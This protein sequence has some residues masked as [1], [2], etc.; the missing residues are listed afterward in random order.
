MDLN[1][2]TGYPTW[3]ILICILAGILGSMVL[4]FRE[5]KNEFPSWLKRLLG[6]IRF[7]II[8]LLSFL[9]LSP[10]LKLSSRATERP[11][12]IFAQDNSLSMVL[13]KDSVYYRNNYIPELNEM[14]KQLLAGF[15]VQLFT[16]GEDVKM[17]DGATFDSL[18]FKEKESD[19]SA[20][21]DMMD[22]SFVNR[23]IGAV[24]IAGDGIYNK[25]FNPVYRAGG[26]D[27]PVY[28]IGLGDTAV[29][30][31]AFFKRVLHNSIAFE[32]NDHPV[33]VIVN[34][35]QMDGTVL[36][37]TISEKA[38]V[39]K[40]FQQP[41][42]GN[43]FSQTILLQLPAGEEGLHH[44]VLKLDSRQDELTYENN[45]YDMFVE[46]L[47]SR[48]KVLILANAP[49]PD[50]S[51]IRQAV[52]SNVNYEVDDV[53]L[54]DLNVPLE[55]YNL[56]ILHQLPSFSPNSD[57][58]M[59]RIARAELPVLY[60]PG[61]QTDL[62][63]FGML[64]TGIQMTGPNQG[65]I[66][67]VQAYLN[68][69]FNTF[70]IGDGL[71]ELL[72]FLPPLN[73]PASRFS[74]SNSARV[75][76]NQKI[77]EVKSP[78]PLW[79]FEEGAEKKTGVIAGTGIWKWRLKT[80]II[81]GDHKP[82][83]ELISKTV[84]YL[85]V[86]DDKRRFRVSSRQAFPENEAVSLQAELYNESFEAVNG[87]DVNV[88]IRDEDG[89]VYNYVFSRSG[90]AYILNA[91]G[92]EVGSYTYEATTRL[93]EQVFSDRGGFVVTPVIKEQSRLVAEHAM[94]GELAESKGGMLLDIEQLGDLPQIL[95]G[96]EDMKPLIHAEKKYI[97]F[98]DL[99]WV[100]IILI[101]LLGTEWFLRKWG[102]SY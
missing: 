21:F 64:R 4:Y 52:S 36:D 18:S 16:Y 28:T 40:S 90:D 31:D 22:V 95:S 38:K 76:F 65:N 91:G 15:D 75:L 58:L 48:Q 7:F 63:K 78:E 72:P 47:K 77:G 102:G 62:R 29:Q 94:L 73:V 13:N 80:H 70:A 96:R 26:A 10:L 3:F 9:L 66:N 61:R 19:I 57:R 51:A 79:L 2:I 32:G 54:K 100:L 86:R 35:N 89:N 46:V 44:Y 83:D 85:A 82:F 56:L 37:L 101:G 69:S 53:L 81:S 24:V 99:W 25:G 50:I 5:N 6:I 74:A 87:P 33:E 34:A 59:Q 41:V 30:R 84:Q 1:I 8:T 60:I 14:L 49:H 11:I 12:V 17:I 67:E 93:G 98:V 39:I 88:E 42:Q 97:D 20:L 43:N 71:R 45:S 23:N 68:E 27:Y 55:A 92:L